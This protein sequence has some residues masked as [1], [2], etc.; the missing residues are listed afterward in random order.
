MCSTQW[1]TL[2]QFLDDKSLEL[3]GYQADFEKPEWSLFYFTHHIEGC[4][5]TM[6]IEAK[7]FLGLY[8]GK[9]YTERRTGM[10]DCPGYCLDKEQLNRCDALC[11]CA[12]NREVMQI[13]KERKAGR[14]AKH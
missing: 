6:V 8:S 3:N 11:E 1:N 5:S 9:K 2:D 14:V 13:I 7:Q 12:Y 4:Y 10:E